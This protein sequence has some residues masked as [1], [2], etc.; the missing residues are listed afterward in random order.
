MASLLVAFK[1]YDTETCGE[2][3]IIYKGLLI[4]DWG[5]KKEKYTQ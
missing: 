3:Y 4:T 5:K 2:N 1:I